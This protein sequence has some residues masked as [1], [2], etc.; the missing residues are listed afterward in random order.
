MHW[1]SI[2]IQCVHSYRFLQGVVLRQTS[3]SCWT[4]PAVLDPP[5]SR[6]CLSLLKALPRTSTLGQMMFRSE[7]TLSHQ[8][9]RPNST[10]TL[11]PISNPWYPPS[12]TFLT[13]LDPLI[14]GKPSSL[15]TPTA[16][17]LLQ[18]HVFNV[19]HQTKYI[20]FNWNPGLSYEFKIVRCPF[21]SSCCMMTVF[22]YM[23]Y[24]EQSKSI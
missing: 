17:Q 15:C 7:S 9:T 8:A 24:P 3:S 5:I 2:I 14:L 18:V 22:M 6:K 21:H 20:I 1:Y 23:V 19:I 16:S 12:V 11:T 4:P 13:S 10:W